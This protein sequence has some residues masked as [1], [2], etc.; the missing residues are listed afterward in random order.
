[1]NQ[2]DHPENRL[3]GESSPYLLLHRHNPVDWYP[4]GAEALELARAEERPIFLS[5]GY[6]T[7]Y[8]C[9]VME[10]ES[11]SDE[12]VAELMNREFVNIK[13]DREERPDLDEIYMTAT[14]VMT[15][16]G[17]WPNS[18]FLTPELKPFFAGTYFPPEDRQGMPSFTR[19]L[20]SM[21]EAWRSRRSEVEQQAEGVADAIR[22]YLEERAQPSDRTPGANLAQES[23]Q[24][25]GRRFDARWGGFG[26]APKFPAPSNLMLLEELVEREPFAAQMLTETLDQMARGGIYDRLGGGFHRYATDDEWKIPHFEKMLYDNGL[27]LELYAREWH[28]NGDPEIALILRETGG[29]LEREMTD[30]QGAFWSA[31]DAETEGVEGAFYAWTGDELRAVLGVEDFGFLAPLYGF[32][33]APFFEGD[34]YVLHLPRPLAEQASK[35]QME[36][37]A[38]SAQVD[39]LRARL[40][41]ARAQRQAPLT[42]RKVMADWNGMAIAGLAEAGRLLPEPAFVERAAAAADAVVSRLRPEG[43]LLHVLRGDQPPVP[44]FLSDY[45]YLT[46]GLLA[47]HRA[48]AGERWL[49]LAA[50]LTD[51][52]IERLEDPNGGF[53][54][55]AESA[56]VLFRS[57]EAFDG[58]TPAANSIAALNLIELAE[59]TGDSRWRAIAERTL[60]AFASLVEQL[61]DGARTMALAAKRFG[62]EGGAAGPAT[63]PETEPAA[64]V[65]RPFSVA[66]R[67]R[68][69]A[70][71]EGWRAFELL[72]DL[73]EGWH[74]YAPGASPLQGVELASDDDTR[75]VELS[76]EAR[77]SVELDGRQ[78]ETWGGGVTISGEIRAGSSPARLRLS[79]QAC[80]SSRCLAPETA[81]LEL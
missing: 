18:V 76:A 22:R 7:C 48:G 55:A 39:K 50:E 72:L 70:T 33:Q 53:F 21:A 19:V 51:E 60:R 4:W 75:E 49:D 65:E 23:F 31:L 74:V 57:K 45:V 54:V 44:A 10:R 36:L 58:A 40:F 62:A 52:Q 28:R 26:G 80:D 34:H 32:D 47:L 5:V 9:H 20:H 69:E 43:R 37:D 14:Q 27:L 38:L 59:V 79:F 13:L 17:G 6:S 2:S 64:A 71:E 1:M 63:P 56:E 66:G 16:H 8:W 73:S 46:R 30:D 35:R 24:A 42:D 12:G 68:G 41:E 78:I 29:W 81:V 77:D 3:G 25:L 11:F 61:P 67:W 15:Q